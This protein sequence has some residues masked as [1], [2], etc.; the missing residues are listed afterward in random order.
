MSTNELLHGWAFNEARV[1][2]GADIGDGV[3]EIGH[4]NEDDVFSAV[5]TVDTG[6]YFQPQ[7][8]EPL[9]RA[10]LARIN[11]P[12]ATDAQGVGEAPKA[13]ATVLIGQNTPWG[14]GTVLQCWESGA[15]EL[16]PGEHK[17][18]AHPTA[19]TTAGLTEA[20]RDDAV[21]LAGKLIDAPFS[22]AYGFSHDGMR[23]FIHALAEKW[24]VR[25]D[26]GAAK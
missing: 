18:Y 14:R 8:A 9:A 17:L 10:I 22:P 21:R 11:S 12:T 16:S 23:R 7:D 24:N 13:V 6:N 1:A 26:G 4:L 15:N 3:W 20:A 19:S 2:E 5:V 25:L